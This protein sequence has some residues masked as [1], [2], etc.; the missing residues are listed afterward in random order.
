MASRSLEELLPEV[1][2]RAEAWHA[3]CEV[4]GVDPLIYCTHRSAQ[5]QDIL[6]AQGRTSVGRIVTFAKGWQSWHQYRRAWDAVPLVGGKPLWECAP[7]DPLWAVLIEEAQR[8]GIEWGGL[9]PGRKRDCPH[10]Q[11]REGLNFEDA[12]AILDEYE[13]ALGEQVTA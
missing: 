2:E 13:R 10:W 1:R 9:W 5:E 11:V 3:A 6:F 8:Q 7:S 12:R 4:R